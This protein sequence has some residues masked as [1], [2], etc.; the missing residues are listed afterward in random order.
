MRKNKLCFLLLIIFALL[1]AACNG[2]ITENFLVGG[3]TVI[4]G[5]NTGSEEDLSNDG[6]FT[7]RA[8]WGLELDDCWGI[9]FIITQVAALEIGD[10]I[11]RHTFEAGNF[12]DTPATIVENDEENIFIIERMTNSGES[13][14]VTLDKTD[15]RI[16]QIH[17]ERE[18]VDVTITPSMALEIGNAALRLVFGERI[19]EDSV[20]RVVEVIDEDAF[21]VWRIPRT[22]YG[23][24]GEFPLAV[25]NGKNGRIIQVGHN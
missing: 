4:S 19:F 20:F 21:Y 17:Q 1:L 25:I 3:D 9:D 15:A 8:S 6:R 7:I 12:S 5:R 24:D 2:V 13:I 11:F 23:A 14:N 18:L 10:A 16:V 22:A